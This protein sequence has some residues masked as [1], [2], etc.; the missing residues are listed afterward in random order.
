LRV[1]RFP[2]LGENLR[3]LC[4]RQ[5]QRE[6]A[7]E[8]P[9]NGWPARVAGWMSRP[10]ELLHAALLLTDA[11]S[12]SSSELTSMAEAV[13][14]D[15]QELAFARLA[16]AERANYPR[17][18]VSRLLANSW[19]DTKSQLALKLGVHP[20]TFS[21]WLNGQT[22]DRSARRAMRDHFGLRSESDVI[23][24]PLFLS[25]WPLTHGERIA[26]IK[27]HAGTLTPEQMRSVFPAL[28]KLLS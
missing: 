10:D 25:Y 20:S 17:L 14:T 28:A 16:E 11:V 6:R 3:W 24:E 22:P 8:S 4:W 27:E 5:D 18:N 12:P 2:Y 13:H 23:E 7:R 26:W 15:E 1:S 19:P 9:R 21:R